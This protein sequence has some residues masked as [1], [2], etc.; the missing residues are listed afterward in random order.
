MAKFK[1]PLLT[2][3]IETIPQTV[4]LRSGIFVR[5]RHKR[6]NRK[7]WHIFTSQEYMS[8][9]P[10]LMTL[11]LPSISIVDC[12]AGIGLFSLLIEHLRRID[13]LPWEKVFYILIEPS[14]YNFITLKDNIMRNFPDGSYRLVNEL[15]GLDRG[16]SEFY[17]SK[18]RPFSSGLFKNN[19][20]KGEFSTIRLPFIDITELLQAN[21]SI[22]K[23]DIEGAEFIFLETYREALSNVAALIIEWHSEIG[24]VG[25]GESIL[26]DIGLKKVKRSWDE[27]KWFT[28]LYLKI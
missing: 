7:F 8:F 21:P 5:L 2:K 3:I 25:K 14:P 9:I 11:K 18:E 23:L 13:N 17:E 22:L 26:S 19:F 4:C 28:D 24:D 6:D 10:D 15:V 1:R 12:G 27:S 16:V 20:K